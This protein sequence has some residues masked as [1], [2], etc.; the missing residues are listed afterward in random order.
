VKCFT[1]PQEDVSFGHDLSRLDR[2]EVLAIVPRFRMVSAMRLDCDVPMIHSDQIH[3]E[4]EGLERA[5]RPAAG[6]AGAAEQV[7]DKHTASF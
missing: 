7:G 1:R 4:T 5:P 3:L 2:V 6:T